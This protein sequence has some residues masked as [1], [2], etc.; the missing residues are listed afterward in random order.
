MT[1][2]E[3]NLKNLLKTVGKVSLTEDEMHSLKWLSGWEI[4]TVNNIC[5]V[6]EKVKIEANRS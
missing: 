1:L 4:E 3:K 6:I 2:Q 5:S